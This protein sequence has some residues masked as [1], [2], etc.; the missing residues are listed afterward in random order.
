MSSDYDGEG[1]TPPAPPIRHTSSRPAD[2]QLL[3]GGTATLSTLQSLSAH[4]AGHADKP[5]PREPD[6]KPKTPKI[7]R[8]EKKEVVVVRGSRFSSCAPGAGFC[9]REEVGFFSAGD[10]T[11]VNGVV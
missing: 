1:E 5:L 2:G 9:Y 6:K 11:F 4:G 10:L 3:G 7:K 8:G